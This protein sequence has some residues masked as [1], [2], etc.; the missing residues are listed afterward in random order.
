MDS[1]TVLLATLWVTAGVFVGGVVTPLI[2]ARKRVNEW[3]ATLAGVVLGGVG[4]VFLLVPLW[5]LL[6]LRPDR[7]DSG[8]AWQRDAISLGEALAE[9]GS[10]SPAGALAALRANFW[11][12]ARSKG[13]SHR[14]TYL[15][16]F[17]ALAVITGVEVLLTVVDVP[18]AVTGPL[19]GLSTGKVMLVAL[20]FMHLRYDSRWYAAV[21]ASALPFALLAS[22]ILA[23]S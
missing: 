1:D 11:P 23:L 20:Y 7:E 6:R 8:P 12:R 13:H 4:G 17:L 9:T 14:L 15:G 21:F 22:V 5:L 3:L 19:V 16:V 10:G 18:F 2:V